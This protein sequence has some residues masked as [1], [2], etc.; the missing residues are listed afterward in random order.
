MENR[1]G[2]GEVLLLVAVALIWGFNFVML[3][4]GLDDMP[5]FLFNALRFAIVIP[6]ILFIPKPDLSWSRLIQLGIVFGVLLFGLLL[7][8]MY[9]GV[10]AGL[11]S[12]IMQT[13]VFFTVLLGMVLLAERPSWLRWLAML[14]GFS[15]IAIIGYSMIEPSSF[16][17]KATAFLS[18]VG[19]AFCW[20]I[21]NIMM[22]RMTSAGMQSVMVW[23]S[24]VPPLPLYA[25]SLIMDGQPRITSALVNLSWVGVI[26]VIYTGLISTALAYGIWGTML[27]RHST[28]VV[29]PFALLVPVFGF[30]LSAIFL[31]EEYS[32]LQMTAAGVVTAGLA[33]NVAA[34]YLQ[35]SRFLP[36]K[37]APVRAGPV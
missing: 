27:K 11:A 9:L 31:G 16:E 36:R 28:A 21:A 23:L 14:I 7:L 12:L 5:P 3:K 22:K 17:A 32:V 35:Q 37:K 24:L 30:S 13:Q 26:A 1:L 18:V 10:P 15:G 34:P 19:A 4:V 2:I 8:G 33:L 6:C 25:M 20:G 29:T